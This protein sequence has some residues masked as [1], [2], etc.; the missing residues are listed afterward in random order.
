[1]EI[2]GIM[3]EGCCGKC[4]SW[5]TFGESLIILWGRNKSMNQVHE[6]KLKE[7]FTNKNQWD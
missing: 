7:W 4:G 3:I 6:N 2:L 1:M 5:F